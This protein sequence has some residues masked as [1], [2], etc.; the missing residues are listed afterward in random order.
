MAAEQIV[1]ILLMTFIVNLPCYKKSKE[2]NISELISELSEKS[3]NKNFTV[4]KFCCYLCHLTFE[5]FSKT[6]KEEDRQMNSRFEDFGNSFTVFPNYKNIQ[7]E[8]NEFSLKVSGKISQKFSSIIS[9][10]KKGNYALK[11]QRENFIKNTE[12]I[13][14]LYQ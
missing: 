7:I 11:D 4:S 14:Y 2:V 12:V 3:A 9:D 6:M 8:K 1:V 10:I 13:K 5:S